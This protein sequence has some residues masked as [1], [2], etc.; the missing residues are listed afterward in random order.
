MKSRY[1][2]RAEEERGQ[3]EVQIWARTPATSNYPGSGPEIPLYLAHFDGQS[4]PRG[5]ERRRWASCETKPDGNEAWCILHYTEFCPAPNNPAIPMF[6]IV[7]CPL[8]HT[9]WPK[10]SPCHQVPCLIPAQ[11]LVQPRFRGCQNSSL[12]CVQL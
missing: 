11:P 9:K 12:W 10:V 6:L 8:L 4:G 5:S 2:D 7:L 3:S 1:I